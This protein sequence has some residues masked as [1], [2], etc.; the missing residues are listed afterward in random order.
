MLFSTSHGL[1]FSAF[2]IKWLTPSKYDKPI[3][4]E[5]IPEILSRYDI[6]LIQEIRGDGINVMSRAIADLSSLTGH[7]YGY[8]MSKKTGRSSYKEQYAY[9]Y[10]QD[11]GF[12]VMT[13]LQYNDTRDVFERE[14]Y[15][16]QID[17]PSLSV[18]T[19][20]IIGAHIKP[21]DTVAELN[22]LTLVYDYAVTQLGT[23]NILFA[24]D[25]NADCS[26]LRSSKYNDL[27]LTT[28]SRFKWLIGSDA[29]TTV[30][31]NTDC[32]YDRFLTSRSLKDAVVDGSVSVFNYQTAFNLSYEQAKIVTDHFPIA[33]ELL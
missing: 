12:S 29:D 6:I 11:A 28:D 20:G 10:R 14:P 15:I 3:V 19:F 2:N 27:L 5:I 1:V 33:L 18:K 31:T 17:T 23:E 30:S 25:F 13:A 26:Y 7:T 24:G 21:D 8:V 4:S 22:N 16:V 9:V 32:A